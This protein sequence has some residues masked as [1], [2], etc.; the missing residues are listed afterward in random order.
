MNGTQPGC[1]SHLMR[2]ASTRKLISVLG[3]EPRCPSGAQGAQNPH[4]SNTH[5][6]GITASASPLKTPPLSLLSARPG[7]VVG[8]PD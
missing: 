2:S 1:Q 8:V 3:G 6:A 7:R 4:P 5:A